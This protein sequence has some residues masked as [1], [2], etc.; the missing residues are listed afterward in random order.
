MQK[1]EYT[2]LLL[3]AGGFLFGS[4]KIDRRELHEALNAAGADGWEICGVVDT[5]F[6]NGQ[7]RDV[8]VLLK[9]PVMA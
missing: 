3:E 8:V 5:N 9:R 7:T 2:T 4:G 6:Y 1:W